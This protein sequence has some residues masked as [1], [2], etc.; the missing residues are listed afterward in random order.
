MFDYMALDPE[1]RRRLG[2]ASEVVGGMQPRFWEEE[3]PISPLLLSFILYILIVDL[4]SPLLFGYYIVRPE[5]CGIAVVY[6]FSCFSASLLFF[7]LSSHVSLSS[8]LFVMPSGLK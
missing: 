1:E 6:L 2:A 8:F 7:Y 4:D 3:D 5:P